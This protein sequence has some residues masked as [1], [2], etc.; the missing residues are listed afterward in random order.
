LTV[1]GLAADPVG[2]KK[3]ALHM[4]GRAKLAATSL[5]G[6][7]ALA[8]A[9]NV[10][11]AQQPPQQPR[12]FPAETPAATRGPADGPRTAE[13]KPLQRLAPLDS[14]APEGAALQI[15]KG[16]NPDLLKLLQTWQLRSGQVA[17]IKG[18]FKRYEYDSVFQTCKCATGNYWYQAPD[19]GRMD[20]TP[21]DS[22]K[23]DPPKQVK[24]PGNAAVFTLEPA[25]AQQWICN[26][27][28]VLDIDVI[29]KQYN[30]VEIPPQ[31]RGK[32]ISD[33]PLPFIFG[34]DAQKMQDRYILSTG[35]LHDPQKLIHIIAI[36]K[37]PA[38]QREYRVA[39]VLLD[40]ADYLP[41]GVR[42]QD[43]TG[44][45]L[46]VYAFLKHDQDRLP[47]LPPGPFNPVLPGYKLMHD[48]KDVPASPTREALNPKKQE[49][50]FLLK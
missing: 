16:I 28:A 23:A 50:G 18:E 42:L 37:Q 41:K 25:Q 43:P 6:F 1:S 34:M 2:E 35:S 11:Q 45:K 14:Q 39:E 7:L 36:P 44:N 20:F 10:A 12:G 49:N 38:E 26:G 29:N 46:T 21:D 33:G 17:R 15:E 4:H 27:D 13:S 9:W 30:R 5:A 31:Y 24:L 40:P 32:N 22:V 47:W 8:G 19:K 48:Y 3:A